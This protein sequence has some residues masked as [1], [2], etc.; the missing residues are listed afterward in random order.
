MVFDNKINQIL[1]MYLNLDKKGTLY[2]K[3]SNRES[4]S[5]A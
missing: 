3:D 5:S 4:N 1:E 2:P